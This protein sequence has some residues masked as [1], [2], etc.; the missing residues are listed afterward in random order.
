VPSGATKYDEISNH[1]IA[2]LSL[3]A[4]RSLKDVATHFAFGGNWASY[5]RTIDPDRIAEAESGLM[6]LVGRGDLAGQRFLDI[7][8]GPGSTL[9]Q[10][11]VW[12][13]P[14]PSQS[15]SMRSPCRPPQRC[16]R[17]TRQT[18]NGASARSASLTSSLIRS[19][20]SGSSIPGASFTTPAPCS[21]P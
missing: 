20:H 15:I 19:D 1:R 17:P 12:E 10:P 16:Y 2:Q 14:R 11:F 4:S 9:W 21:M 6:R 13:S 5:A 7:A 18:D 8:A 3:M